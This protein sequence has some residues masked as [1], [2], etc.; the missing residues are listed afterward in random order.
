MLQQLFI[1]NIVFALIIWGFIYLGDYYLTL[2]GARLYVANGKEH[3]SIQGSYELT[4]TFQK[5]VDRLRLVSPRFFA[6]VVLSS[7]LIFCI[8]FLSVQILA[9][10]EFY[11]FLLGGL[12]LREAVIH[13]RHWR[14]ITTF[15]LAAHP[16]AM[17]GMIGYSKWTSYR[18]SATE[19]LSFAVLYLLI[20]LTVGSWFLF[21][22]A[23]ACMVLSIQHQLLA[24]RML[25]LPSRA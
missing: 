19:L 24:R 21:G 7:A 4:P 14:N 15:R 10:P 6:F 5:D 9:M 23:F 13:I 12:M 3:L 22:G 17:Q 11:L 16:N 8:W 2:Y 20:G 18:M 25:K 1:D